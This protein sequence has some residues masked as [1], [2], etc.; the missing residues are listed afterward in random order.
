MKH[1]LG[2]LPALVVALCLGLGSAAV[3]QQP[4]RFTGRLTDRN[5]GAAL[6]GSLAVNSAWDFNLVLS[7]GVAACIKLSFE[8]TYFYNTLGGFVT[9]GMNVASAPNQVISAPITTP[10]P[11]AL[12]NL[13]PGTNIRIQLNNLPYT[14]VDSGPPW[15]GTG[16]PP[17]PYDA[18]R[19]F[20]VGTANVRGVV[21]RQHKPAHGGLTVRALRG[22]T[23][24]ATTTTDALGNYT[25]DVTPGAI[26]ITATG[27]QHLYAQRE[28]FNVALASNT[29]VP[30]V[31]LLAGDLDGD[32]DVDWND[33]SLVGP[34][35]TEPPTPVSANDARDI[36]GNL[37]IDWDDVAKVSANTGLVAPSPW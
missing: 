11:Y 12:Y 37:L 2:S 18:C 10:G 16:L 21:R 9:L 17:T 1:S 14:L 32:N 8:P 15:G 35:V 27:P 33:V 7:P 13:P 19:K 5:T 23:V 3:A 29:Y 22:S 4:Q 28:S 30:P 34:C 31:T 24:L 6:V 36:N 25:F 26:S 20:S